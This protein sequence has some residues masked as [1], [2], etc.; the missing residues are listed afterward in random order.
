VVDEAHRHDISVSV[1]GEMAGDPVLV[2]LLLGLGVDALSMTPPLIP[3]VRYLVRAMK[4]ADAKQLA[5]AALGLAAPK[6][7]HALCLA[8]HHE[9]VKLE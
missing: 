7:I 8:F 2:P 9:R 5:Q 3:A 1:C 6:E 4:L